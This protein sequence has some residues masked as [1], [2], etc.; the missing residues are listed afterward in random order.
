MSQRVTDADVRSGRVRTSR[1]LLLCCS[2]CRNRFCLVPCALCGSNEGSIEVCPTCQ[3]DAPDEV[4]EYTSTGPRGGSLTHEVGGYRCLKC[5]ELYISEYAI[6]IVDSVATAARGKVEIIPDLGISSSASIELIAHTSPL[7]RGE[8]ARAVRRQNGIELRYGQ[9]SSLFARARM[10]MLSS[11]Y[12]DDGSIVYSTLRIRPGPPYDERMRQDIHYLL[13]RIQ[14]DIDSP[15]YFNSSSIQ[16]LDASESNFLAKDLGKLL[17]RWSADTDRRALSLWYSI[18]SEE[19][20]GRFINAF[21]LL[22]LVLHRLIDEDIVQKRRDPNFKERAFIELVALYSMDLKTRLQ[23]RVKSMKEEPADVLRNL[24]KACHPHK[25]YNPDGVYDSIVRFR[26]MYAHK[27]D[28]DKS[29]GGLVLPWEIP[30]FGL[31]IDN[32]LALIT[33]ILAERVR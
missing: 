7:G 31:F 10:L 22:E 11:S 12:F 3:S 14:L 4:V 25:R 2:A 29:S 16:D 17:V 26:N 20:P 1:A 15:L 23:R 9:W 28:G 32:L 30:A 8:P 33:L 27:P 13:A 19:A 18:E 21:R 5:K 24:W 6:E